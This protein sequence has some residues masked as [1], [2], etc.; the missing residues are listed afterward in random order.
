MYRLKQEMLDTLRDGRTNLYLCEELGITS[1]HIC[2]ILKGNKCKLLIAKSL[3]S[4]KEKI[5]INDDK[6]EELLNYYFDKIQ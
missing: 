2:N 6:M 5:A 3:I 1:V 4:I